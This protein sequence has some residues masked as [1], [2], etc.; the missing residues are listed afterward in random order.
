VPLEADFV[1]SGLAM[2][3]GRC[4]AHGRKGMRGCGERASPHVVMDVVI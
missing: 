1:P 4:L 3:A 2:I